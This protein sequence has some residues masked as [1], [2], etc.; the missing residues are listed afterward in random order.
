MVA[1]VGQVGS[2]KSVLFNTIIGEILLKS[3][4]VKVNGVV[5]YYSQTPWLFEAT[6]R[7]NILFGSKMNRLRYRQVLK[8]CQLENDLVSFPFGDK[9]IVGERGKIGY[10]FVIST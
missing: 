8:C 3:G 6:I 9:T 1:I 2:G 4:S 5:S 7:Q 10:P